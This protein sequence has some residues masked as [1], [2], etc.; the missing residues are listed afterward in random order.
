MARVLVVDDHASNRDLVV[1]LLTHAG[2]ESLEAADGHLALAQVRAARP[3][4][5]ICDI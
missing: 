2:H 5:V 1:A 4:L 3:D